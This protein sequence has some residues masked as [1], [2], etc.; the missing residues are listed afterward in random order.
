MIPAGLY[1]HIPFCKKKC[2]YCDFYSITTTSAKTDYVFAL[3]KEIEFVA[4]SFPNFTFDS[5]YFGGGTPTILATDQIEAIWSHLQRYFQ[6]LKNS[7]IT[8]EVNPGT[9]NLEILDPL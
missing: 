6:I 3:K 7:E 4:T 5:I 8:I 2:G 1:I 9:V